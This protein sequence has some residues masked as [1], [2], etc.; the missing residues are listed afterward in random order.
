MKKIKRIADIKEERMRLRIK[1]LELEKKMHNNWI[2]IKEEFRPETFLRNKLNSY[3]HKEV[4]EESF[5]ATAVNYGVGYLAKKLLKKTGGKKY[6]KRES[7][8]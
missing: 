4:K 8:V 2:E 5:L 6:Q 7:C 1:E 3:L